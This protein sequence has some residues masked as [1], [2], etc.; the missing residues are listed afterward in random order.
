[1]GVGVVEELGGG[2]V[3][4]VVALWLSLPEPYSGASIIQ[5][6]DS[7]LFQRGLD[8]GKGRG[9]GAYFPAKG[10]HAAD[11]ADGHTGAFGKIRLR[12]VEQHARGS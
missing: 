7:G 1:M 2:Y 8:L 4:S 6:L 5:K 11:G 3:E 12:P 10:L 9:A